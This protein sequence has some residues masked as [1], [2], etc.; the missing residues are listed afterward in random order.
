MKIQMEPHPLQRAEVRGTD[1]EEI[2]IVLEDG[3]EIMPEGIGRQEQR[4]SLSK[5]NDLAN[6]T[7]KNELK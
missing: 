1:I 6:I 5:E 7:K 3:T 2:Q 4:Y